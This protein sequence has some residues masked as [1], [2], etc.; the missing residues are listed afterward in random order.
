[1]EE[2]WQSATVRI[3]RVNSFCHMEK[4]NQ[5][6]KKPTGGKV[7]KSQLSTKEAQKIKLSTHYYRPGAVALRE[8]RKFQMRV[9]LSISNFPFQRLDR[10]LA[11]D[12]KSETRF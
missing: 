2:A 6:A 4:S 8:I 12:R 3:L 11:Q 7:Q 1:M 10:E 9:S 5:T